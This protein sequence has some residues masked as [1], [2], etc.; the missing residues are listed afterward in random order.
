MAD[1]AAS[2][3]AARAFAVGRPRSK[4]RTTHG[5]ARNQPSFLGVSI[6]FWGFVGKATPLSNARR[7]RWRSQWVRRESP[8]EERDLHEIIGAGSG[9]HLYCSRNA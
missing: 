6:L 5:A 1:W 2:V 3:S 7:T 9:D 8:S 4:Y